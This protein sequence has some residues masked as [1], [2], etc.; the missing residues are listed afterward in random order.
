MPVRPN[1]KHSHSVPIS[2]PSLQLAIIAR[3][4]NLNNQ[5]YIT[6]V[7]FPPE[8]GAVLFIDRAR[9]ARRI[10]NEFYHWPKTLSDKRGAPILADK[11]L[12]SVGDP[13]A[14]GSWDVVVRVC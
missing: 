9:Q 6:L 3:L 7:L 13:R 12:R 8:N 4:R 10:P 14:F 5:D 2:H 11:S 1:N